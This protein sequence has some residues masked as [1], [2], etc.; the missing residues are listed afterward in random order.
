MKHL[1]RYQIQMYIDK[2]LSESKRKK[3]E[4]HL[5]ECH[6]CKEYEKDIRKEIYLL[7]KNIKNHKPVD[8]PVLNFN[9]VVKKQ[10]FKNS[11]IRIPVP[12]FSLMVGLILVMGLMLLTRSDKTDE[13]SVQNTDKIKQVFNYVKLE[14]KNSNKIISVDLDLSEYK[15]IKKPKIRVIREGNNGTQSI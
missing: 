10:K 6:I 9:P 1:K 12:V 13:F 2:G 7:K 5:A 14:S 8:K 11:Y 3:T 15:F 4:Q